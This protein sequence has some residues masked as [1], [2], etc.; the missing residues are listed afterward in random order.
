MPHHLHRPGRPVGGGDGGA[1]PGR[2]PGRAGGDRAPRRPGRARR[3]H[4]PLPAGRRRRPRPAG[5]SGPATRAELEPSPTPRACTPGSRR[6]TRWRPRG[7]SRRTGAGSC[8]PSR[9]PWAAAGRSPPSVPGSRATRPARSSRSASAG[10]APSSRRASSSASPASSTTA[11]STRSGLA[12]E[13]RRPVPH[14]PP[15]ARLPRAAR[16]PRRSHA[17]STRPSHLAITRTR[18]FAGRQERWFRRDP[19]IRWV[20]ATDDPVAALDRHRAGAG[21]VR[22]TLTKHHGLGND[23]LVL[24]DEQPPAPAAARRPR[25]ALCDRRR[26]IGADGLILGARPAPRGRR[27]RRR[28][29]P[30]QRRRQPGR[31]ER[32]RHP[33][34]GPGVGAAR[35]P[36]TE[37]DA[38]GRHR[39][40]PEGRRRRAGS[41]PAHDRRQRGHGRRPSPSRRRRAG[42][43]PAATRC[44]P[45]RT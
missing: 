12:G 24:L 44:D 45:C 42:P 38:P 39:C 33:L 4:R 1:V 2:G 3:R 25:P 16:P 34:P 9:S 19:R 26:G 20:D 11:S 27:R 10:R 8:G 37:G 23:F 5:A 6:S 32:Q 21:V 22:V 35:R 30:V 40:R 13:A 14:G 18:R 7:W 15:G 43:R 41:R 29:G 36:S 31:D 28:D 17:R